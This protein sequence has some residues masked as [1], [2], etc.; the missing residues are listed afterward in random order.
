M[1]QNYH[2][3]GKRF[4]GLRLFPGKRKMKKLYVVEK[5]STW[6]FCFSAIQKCLFSAFQRNVQSLLQES[7]SKGLEHVT[8]GEVDISRF[9]LYNICETLNNEINPE[10]WSE[11]GSNKNLTLLL[12]R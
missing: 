1:M 4:G 6:S 9:P 7:N 12:I 8:N 11:T 2:A 3:D 5:S 10:W